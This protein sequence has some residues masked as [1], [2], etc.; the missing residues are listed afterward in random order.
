MALIRRIRKAVSK[1]WAASRPLRTVV[2]VSGGTAGSMLVGAATWAGARLRHLS[3]LDADAPEYAADTP[4]F[5][6]DPP[7]FS[8]APWMWIPFGLIAFWLLALIVVRW[9]MRPP[10]T[11]D[12]DPRREFTKSD[13]EWIKACT[14]DR[15]EH[16]ALG[17][18]R[19]RRRGRRV[20]FGHEFLHDMELD[21]HYPHSKGGPTDRHNLV[22]LCAEHN[23]A[24][25]D[26]VPGVVETWLL[27]RAR[28]R[29]FPARWRG[30]ARIRL[31]D[32]YEHSTADAN[33][34]RRKT[35]RMS[36]GGDD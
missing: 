12:R 27:Y 35:S 23:G 25:S 26:R 7:E 32:A 24:K 17:L 31:E 6:V 1:A 9:P 3:E 22:Y 28:L 19:C 36:A 34:D 30:Y 2:A 15:C 16:R 14:G 13:R 20:V 8:F 10:D 5:H 29:Y 33:G 21:H 18:F 11:E 4:E